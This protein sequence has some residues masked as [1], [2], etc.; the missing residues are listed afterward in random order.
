LKDVFDCCHP[1]KQIFKLSINKQKNYFYVTYVFNFDI[2][3]FKYLEKNREMKFKNKDSDTTVVLTSCGRMD[4]LERTLDSFFHFNTYPLNDFIIIEDSGIPNITHRLEEKYPFITWIK[5]TQRLG[6]IKSID[7]AYNLVNSPFIFHLEDDWLFFQSSFIESSLKIIKSQSNI[8]AVML[9][10]YGDGCYNPDENLYVQPMPDDWGY[11][12]FNPGIRRLEDYQKYFNSSYENFTGFDFQN[13]HISEKKINDYY[14][15]LQKRLAL[16]SN[17]QGFIRHI[18]DGRHISEEIPQEPLKI[19]LC[20]I[21][22]NESHIIAEGLSTLLPL[23]DNYVIVDTGSTDNTQQVIKDFFHQFNVPGEIYHRRW[24]NFGHN[25]TEAL[26]LARDHGD[27]S[28]MMD[29]DDLIQLPPNP[30]EILFKLVRKFQPSA[31]L[32]DIIQPE[33]KYTRAHLF[34]NSDHW[35]YKGIIHEYAHNEKNLPL[36]KLPLE[37]AIVSR[38][39][40]DRNKNQKEKFKK[41]I[42]LL[43]KSLWKNPK[44]LRSLYYLA[45]SYRDAGKIK[46]AVKTYE[47]RFNSGGWI[48]ERYLCGVELTYLLS[49][50]EWA[51]KAHNIN[52][53]RAECLFNYLSFARKNNLFSPEIYAMARYAI[54]IPL[55]TYEA[56]MLKPSVYQ[57][58]LLDEFALIAFATQHYK[59]AVEAMEKL[60]SEKKAPALELERIE[61]NYQKMKLGK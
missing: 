40:G 4:L 25:R 11:F 19:T 35:T 61:S 29:A 49:S 59:E 23:I 16:T 18:G 27:Y 30:R 36:V 5:N 12:S 38:R 22:K 7:R 9:R 58:M 15:S 39:L 31:F 21:V 33:I 20:M 37:F 48:E 53:K 43:K 34:K 14:K 24:I 1:S 42:W 47:K 44:D 13:P 60:L 51:W 52:P 32:F 57:W 28:L 8:S 55:P 50:K 10:A 2:F 6:Q 45:Q 54:S 3:I 56:L 46:Q 17:P 26:E 41:D